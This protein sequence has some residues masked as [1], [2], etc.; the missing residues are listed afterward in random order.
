MVVFDSYANVYQAGYLTS[1]N[2]AGDI[3]TKWSS[4]KMI[5]FYGALSIVTF[6]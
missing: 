6:D 2:M 4:G 5:H 1:S 3:P